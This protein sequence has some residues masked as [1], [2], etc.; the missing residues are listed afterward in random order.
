[1]A[2]LVLATNDIIER[3]KQ[4]QRTTAYVAGRNDIREGKVEAGFS[5]VTTIEQNFASNQAETIVNEDEFRNV[6]LEDTYSASSSGE[7]TVVI[8][9][10]QAARSQLQK[11]EKQTLSKYLYTKQGNSAH[12]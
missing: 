9:R 10:Q 1:M 4:H 11:Q 8:T 2:D 7:S 12:S 5:S 3:R 6:K